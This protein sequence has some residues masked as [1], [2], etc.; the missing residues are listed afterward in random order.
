VVIFRLNM[1]C[2]VQTLCA[3]IFVVMTILPVEGKCFA[4]SKGL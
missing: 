2:I 3:L 1:F 4:I